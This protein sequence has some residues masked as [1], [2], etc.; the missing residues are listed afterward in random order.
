MC[1]IPVYICDLQPKE[2]NQCVWNI[3][4][5]LK[6]IKAIR[7]RIWKLKYFDLNYFFL[8]FSWEATKICCFKTTQNFTANLNV[9]IVLYIL[10]IAMSMKY[11]RNINHIFFFCIGWR[12]N[13]DCVNVCVFESEKCPSGKKPWVLICM[14]SI[15]NSQRHFAS[16]KCNSDSRG[17]GAS[18]AVNLTTHRRAQGHKHIF[19]FT[20]WRHWAQINIAHVPIPPHDLQTESDEDKLIEAEN[21]QTQ[22]W[23]WGQ[24]KKKERSE[25]KRKQPWKKE[26]QIKKNMER[27]T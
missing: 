11:W 27:L 26:T 20:K 16:Y 15:E 22:T 5:I 12:K 24:V 7:Y 14:L 17:V 8:L 21:Y 10:L 18:A 6:F 23:E 3:E 2:R 19:N 25:F 4:K 1:W 9:D 13:G